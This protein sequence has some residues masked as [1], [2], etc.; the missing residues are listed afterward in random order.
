MCVCDFVFEWN[1]QNIAMFD[2]KRA[3]GVFMC[4]NYLKREVKELKKMWCD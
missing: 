1:I 2:D 3:F 4:E